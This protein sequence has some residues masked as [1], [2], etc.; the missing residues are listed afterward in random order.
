MAA[1]ETKSRCQCATPC[2][3]VI[4]TKDELDELGD[5]DNEDG[6]KDDSKD[7]G[8][9]D[10]VERWAHCHVCRKKVKINDEIEDEGDYIMCISCKR[11]SPTCSCGSRGVEPNSSGKWSDKCVECLADET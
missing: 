10:N 6:S 1:R 7:D 4:T 2:K 3:I 8:R 5:M 9:D 11:E